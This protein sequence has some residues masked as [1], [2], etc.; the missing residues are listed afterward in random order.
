MGVPKRLTEMQQKF[1]NLLVTNEGRKTAYECAIEAGYEKDRARIT[2]SE[3]QN[4]QKFPLV[5]KYIGELREENQQKYKIDI[6]SHLTELGRLRDEARK[7]KA[8]S[9]ATNAEV[10]RGKA[11]ALY[12]EQKMILTGDIKKASIE[13]MRKE[14]ATI[15]KEYS[16]LIDSETQENIDE[17][18]IPRVKKVSSS[19]LPIDEES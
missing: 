3:L 1:A 12:V 4:P 9:A 8:W 13:D 11:G 15:M 19:S 16:P 2:A 10:A 5:V 18:I 7:N 17:K 14:F 6:E